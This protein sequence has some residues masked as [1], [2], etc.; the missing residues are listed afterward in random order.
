[1]KSSVPSCAVCSVESCKQVKNKFNVQELINVSLISFTV[2]HSK[3]ETKISDQ[4][5][6]L[7]CI[8]FWEAC[9]GLPK[10][11]DYGCES[12]CP[13]KFCNI[14]CSLNKQA[15]REIY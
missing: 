4:L 12:L 8:G 9:L 2:P 1:M 5:G 15:G 3:G 10:C 14:E 13:A 7:L 6:I 11:W